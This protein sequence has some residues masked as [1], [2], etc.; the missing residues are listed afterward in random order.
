MEIKLSFTG[1][2]MCKLPQLKASWIDGKYNFNPVFDKIS[3]VFH[4]SNYVVGNME[5][6]LAGPALGFTKT[7]SNFNAPIEFAM[8]AQQ[9]GFD[10]FAI[11]N[12]HSLDRGVEGL[13][14]TIENL[15]SINAEFTGGYKTSEESVIPFVKQ[16]NGLRI[17]I[18]SYTYGTNSEWLGNELDDSHKDCIDL[19]RKQDSFNS[20]K[21]G[22]SS[23]L[24][25]HLKNFAKKYLPQSIREKIKPIVIEDCVKNP[26]LLPCDKYF[27]NKLK[28]KIRL[29]KGTADVVIMYMHSGGQFNSKVGDYTKNL[30]HRLI[31]YGCD[32]VIGS[33]PHCVLNYEIYK[34][35][36]IAYSLGNFCY[37]PH[38]G[39][40]Y[41]GVFSDYSMIVNLYL[42]TNEKKLTRKTIV[43][44]KTV[45]ESNGNS[46]VYPVSLLV[47]QISEKEKQQLEKDVRSVLRRF[48]GDDIGCGIWQEE[49]DIVS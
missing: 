49:I 35:K 46:V 18:L 17:A 26:D 23:S 28:E 31:D 29:A 10:C 6:P 33:H 16:I 21:Q 5:T 8:A 14:N 34:D 22:S 43:V 3:G 40:H 47:K 27:D 19:F 42:D 7:A 15:K 20:A 11:A 2:L 24:I 44:T 36:F 4:N 48:F 41:D 1:D 9:A 32:Y 37:T 38:Y 45:L 30:A 39:Y 12:N 13:F 25:T